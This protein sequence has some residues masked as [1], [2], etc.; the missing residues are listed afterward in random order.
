MRYRRNSGGMSEGYPHSF[1]KKDFI[2]LANT[3]HQAK[4]VVP[5]KELARGNNDVRIVGM[6]HDV[7][8]NIEHA[9]KFA[10][11]EAREGFHSTYF[12]LHT[13]W[14]YEDKDMLERCMN[15]ILDLGHEIG[16]HHN[17]AGDVELLHTVLNDLRG[18]GYEIVS[19]SA[20]GA[21]KDFLDR[22][23]FYN[24]P[25][26]SFGLE[27]EATSFFEPVKNWTSD[28]HGKWWKEP[29]VEMMGEWGRQLYIL[30]HPCHWDVDQVL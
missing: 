27:Y 1:G 16:C 17:V 20:H 26:S 12:V 24:A 11:W 25:M 2:K 28:N 5:L 10:K 23:V 13:A 8:H 30:I 7:D 22:T 4:A 15:E 14:Y 3:L 6:Q 9:L 21:I 19:S 18:R 29:S